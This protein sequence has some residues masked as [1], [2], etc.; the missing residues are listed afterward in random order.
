MTRKSKNIRL[1][2]CIAAI[3]AAVSCTKETADNEVDI[4]ICALCGE[5][6]SGEKEDENGIWDINLFITGAEGKAEYHR[7]RT[8][9]TAVEE[10]PP[11]KFRLVFGR[12][13]KVWAIANAGFDY[14]AKNEDE[15][16]ALKFYLIYPNH[17]ER[18]FPMAAERE[19]IPVKGAGSEIRLE[20]LV[21]K[22]SVR[23][24]R[25]ALDSDVAFDIAGAK[26]GNCPRYVR[27]FSLSRPERA[28]TDIFPAGYYAPG[29]DSFDVY[30]AEN[31]QGELNP[32]LCSFLEMDIDYSSGEYYTEGGKCL[33]YRFYLREND[34]YDVR[35]N[36]HYRVTVKPEKDGLLCEDSWRVD[37][38]AL[39]RWS[40]DP[41]LKISPNGTLVDGVFYEYYYELERSGSLHFSLAAFPKSMKIWLRD[42]LVLDERED[43]RME[44][45]MD[46]DGRGFTAKSLGKPCL[47]MMD[48][49]TGEPLNE[50]ITIC[51]S[52]E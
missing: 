39:L 48:I 42:D 13:Y 34:S 17:F 10:M 33:K 50:D 31:M 4:E 8:F 49:R 25:S 26:V 52:V 20:R 51:V 21:S 37:K 24:D 7:Y 32:D 40:G 18:G 3:M 45:I 11:E 2:L 12:G 27:P 23:L 6:R 29:G 43:G 9:N 47:S 46:D 1:T 5:T 41:Y 38:S 36:S 22:V 44:Y 19:M 30:L 35:R 16:K 14:G 28:D 15:L